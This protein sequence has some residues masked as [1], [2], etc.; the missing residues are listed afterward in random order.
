MQ[1]SRDVAR[2]SCMRIMSSIVAAVGCLSLLS[3][4]SAG[5]STSMPDSGV[6]DSSVE[7]AQS[8]GGEVAPA[9]VEPGQVPTSVPSQQLA[10]TATVTMTV[11]DVNAAA[12]ALRDLAAAV[13]GQV[14]AE[15]L[16]TRTGAEEPPSVVRISVPAATLDTTLDRLAGLGTIT[17]RV[18]SS[19]DITTEVADVESRIATLTAS[20]DRL[21]ELSKKAGT[22]REL[23]ELESEITN[24]VSERDSLVAQR[25]I[26]AGRVAMSPITITLR[27]PEAASEVE[28]AG[29]LGGL[30]AGWGALVSSSKVLLTIL[31]AVLPFAAVLAVLAAPVLL[32]RR[33]RL[34]RASALRPPATDD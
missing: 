33:R 19:D 20:I 26:L 28:T 23:T 13:G 6:T 8:A 1:R 34:A 29:F 32:W 5:S 25:K 16:V 21:R 15:N 31:G 11:T 22:I 3:G 7:R 12:A 2:D 4:C 24:R 18:I 30:V 17:A 10:R 27:L 9:D 14:T